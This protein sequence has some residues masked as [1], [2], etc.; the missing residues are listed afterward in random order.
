M[1]FVENRLEAIACKLIARRKKYIKLLKSWEK[2][3]YFFRIWKILGTYPILLHGERGLGRLH[4]LT[5]LSLPNDIRGHTAS[6][7]FVPLRGL[8]QCSD[9][10]EQ[11]VRRHIWCLWSKYISL[12]IY[13]TN[14]PHSKNIH[15]RCTHTHGTLI[16]FYA[17]T[18]TPKKPPQKHIPLLY[19]ANAF[20]LSWGISPLKKYTHFSNKVGCSKHHSVLQDILFSESC[21]IC[22]CCELFFLTV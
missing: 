17:H 9:R 6:A 11:W 18:H 7:R 16:T 1:Q 20:F 10:S 2:V 5:P 19:D 21:I 14:Y 12:R 22:R 8:C 4:T 13:T 3:V 15:R